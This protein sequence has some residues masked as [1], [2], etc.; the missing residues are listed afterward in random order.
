M[1]ELRPQ[2]VLLTGASAGIGLAIVHR[3]IEDGYE[4]WGTSRDLSRLPQLPRFHPIS[5]DLRNLESIRTGFECASLEASGFDVL[6]NNAGVGAFGPTAEMQHDVIHEQYQV[7]VH[8]PLELIRLVLPAMLRQQSGCILNLSSL[9]GV[10]PIPFMGAYS[11]A[12]AA[13]SAHTACLRME[14]ANTPIQVV[15]IQPGDIR[16]NFHDATIRVGSESSRSIAVW[17]LQ[18]REMEAA[19]AP[20][21]VASAVARLLLQPNPPPIL[22]VGGFAQ[23]KLAPFLARFTTARSLAWGMRK[24]FGL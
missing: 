4:V 7:L 8:A 16:T 6:I 22:T 23:S 13:L 19:P 18:Q 12:K 15:D 10:F 24:Y 1:P 17:N 9:A 14:L 5:M 11:A 20:K 21:F 2:R 3:L